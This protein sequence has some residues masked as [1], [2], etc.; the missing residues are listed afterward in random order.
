MKKIAET[1]FKSEKTIFNWI[2][3]WDKNG[4]IGLYN[5]KGQ[6]R[7]P[8]FNQEEKAYLKSWGEENPKN[9]K[10]VLGKIEEKW[11]KKISKK[12][13]TR[14]LK[15]LKMSWHRM[16]KICGLRSCTKKS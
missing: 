6:G 14:I 3:A 12:T 15:S 2:K 7:K 8:T 4:L 16:R 1:F 13:L 5:R 9:L 11:Q 10:K